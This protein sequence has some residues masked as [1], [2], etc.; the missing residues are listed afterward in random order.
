M[1]LQK[2]SPLSFRQIS[3]YIIGLIYVFNNLKI[4]HACADKISSVLKGITETN[5]RMNSS[6]V[7]TLK[8]IKGLFTVF[9]N[10]TVLSRHIL[11]KV[12]KIFL[13]QA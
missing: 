5:S 4:K 11:L 6:A 8:A 10:L 3:R 13:C 7:R 12:R 9:M 2:P 1:V